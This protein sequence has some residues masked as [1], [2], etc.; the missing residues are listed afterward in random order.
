VFRSACGDYRV[1][2]HTAHGLRCR[3]PTFPAP[4]VFFGECF[5]HDSDASRRE[6]ANS[7]HS[8]V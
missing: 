2:L 1:L 6:D 7:Y 3:H 5:V 4:S 8:V